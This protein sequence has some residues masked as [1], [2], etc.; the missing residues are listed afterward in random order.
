MISFVKRNDCRISKLEMLDEIEE[1]DLVL[2]H[3]A[4]T[5]GIKLPNAVDDS[6]LKAKWLEWGIKPSVEAIGAETDNE[7]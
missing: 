1:L 4:I 2:Q 3:Y 7:N 5:W 6:K